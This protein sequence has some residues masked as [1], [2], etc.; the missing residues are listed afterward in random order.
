MS[1]SPP[2]TDITGRLDKLNGMMTIILTQL[3][4]LHD[5]G[6]PDVSQI[7]TDIAEINESIDKIKIF[8]GTG[9]DVNYQGLK[10]V[11]DNI[12]D[13]DLQ[14]QLLAVLPTKEFNPLGGRK[15]RRTRFRTMKR[16]RRSKK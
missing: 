3:K 2:P 7:K 9:T 8:I 5:K 10:D 15:R 13:T 1:A 11:I 16:K 4:T 12:T 6:T 14:K